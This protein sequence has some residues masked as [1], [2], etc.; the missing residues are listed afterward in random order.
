[1]IIYRICMYFFI[2]IFLIVVPQQSNAQ[3]ELDVKYMIQEAAECY[4]AGYDAYQEYHDKAYGKKK[5]C[6][7]K[8]L[9]THLRI[10]S[11]FACVMTVW[12]VM[13]ISD[14]TF[15]HGKPFYDLS[16]KIDSIMSRNPRYWH[17]LP[18][19]DW[20]EKWMRADRFMDSS[21]CDDAQECRLE[22]S[23]PHDYD[24]TNWY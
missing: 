21:E 22:G 13:S 20:V 1:M 7:H 12:N 10:A 9:I 17:D 14:L 19:P 24:Y 2:G 11:N 4:E 5:C 6:S 23:M 8:S 18:D 3:E 15:V 16:S